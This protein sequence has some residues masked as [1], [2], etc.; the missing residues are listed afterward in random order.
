MRI[1]LLFILILLGSISHAA[2]LE[3]ITVGKCDMNLIVVNSSEEHAR[4][5]LG[6]TE[7]T[8]PYDGMLF[9]MGSSKRKAF[10]TVGM[11]MNIRIM[12]V[13]KLGDGTYK[14]TDVIQKAPPG[15]K[16]IIIDSPHVLE[17]PETKYQLYFRNCL[18]GK[19]VK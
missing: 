6:Y 7:L 12:G 15:L 17:I 19:E 9:F 1:F 3:S 18:G 16:E 10:H 13:T 2:T 5:L 4:G 11:K 8:F 14:V